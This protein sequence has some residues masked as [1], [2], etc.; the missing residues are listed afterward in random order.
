MLNDLMQM[1]ETAMFYGMIRVAPNATVMTRDSIPA[2]PLDNFAAA[3]AQ[4]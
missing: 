1:A 2:V 4:G 3:T